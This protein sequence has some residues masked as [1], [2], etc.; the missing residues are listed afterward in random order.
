[1]IEIFVLA[2]ALSMDAF[3]VAIGVGTKRATCKRA[4]ALKVAFIFGSFQ[5]LMPI[6]GYIGGEEL[7]IY[8][9]NLYY[10]V[11]SFLLFFIGTKMM[12]DA[13]RKNIEESIE[14]ISNKALVIL[15]IATSIDALSAGFVIHLFEVG[16]YLSLGII[17]VVTFI[18]VY[19]G[20]FVGYKGGDIYKDRAEMF[21]GIIL[22]LI[23]VKVLFIEK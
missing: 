19:I 13:C 14:N 8:V 22:I 16:L 15:A 2:F 18:V 23:G 20:V 4:L 10:L 12:Y 1:V 5:A 6:I 9:G 17:G 7:K 11:S 21:G 3:A